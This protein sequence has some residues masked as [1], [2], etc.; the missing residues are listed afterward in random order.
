VRLALTILVSSLSTLACSPRSASPVYGNTAVPDPSNGDPVAADGGVGLFSC[1]LQLR[2]TSEPTGQGIDPTGFGCFGGCGPSCMAE[3]QESSISR[4]R[5][6]VTDTGV[7]ACVTCRYQLLECKSHAFCRWH[8]DCYLQCDLR[9]ADQRGGAPPDI[10]LNGC[11]RS[12]DVPAL[13]DAR[14]CAVDWAQVA[15]PSVTM[16]DAC[17]DGSYV[18]FTRLTVGPVVTEGSCPPADEGHARPWDPLVAGW[19]DARRPP[20]TLPRGAS[21]TEDTDCP[22]RNQHCDRGR[23]DLPRLNGPGTCVDTFPSPR[24][25]VAPLVPPGLVVPDRKKGAGEGCAL[26]DQCQSGRCLRGVCGG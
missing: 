19:D 21:C 25:N 1:P 2:F 24:V 6:V 9:W 4:S 11:Y 12:C 13:Q 16:D 26:D 8:D 22:D 5:D 23:P 3:C 17:W 18:P 10:P 15:D 14:G 20:G 7:T